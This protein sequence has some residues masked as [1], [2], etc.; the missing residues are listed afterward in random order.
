MLDSEVIKE[1]KRLAAHY[2]GVLSPTDVVNAASPGPY[3]A[4]YSRF[5]WDTE[6]AAHDRR[7]DQARTLLRLTEAIRIGPQTIWTPVF[8]SLSSFRAPQAESYRLTVD[9]R[10]NPQMSL[11]ADIDVLLACERLLQRA[12]SSRL[13]GILHAVALLIATLQAGPSPSPP[14][15]SSPPPPPRPRRSGGH[16]LST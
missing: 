6:R 9:V 13:I 11:E 12:N 4:L 14:P 16:S 15:P 1:L 3:P 5:T 2:G 10:A 8:T 7:L